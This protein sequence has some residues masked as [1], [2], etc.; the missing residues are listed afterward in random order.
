MELYFYLKWGNALILTDRDFEILK[1][2]YKFKFCLGRHLKVLGNFTGQRSTDRRLRLLVDIGYLTRKKYLFGIPYLYTLTHKGRI[3]LGANKREDKIRIDR[4]TH[5]I[6]VLDSVIYFRD[7]Y[8]LVF[9]D[10]ESEKELHIKDGF[11]ARQHRADF[12]FF[13]DDKKHAVEIELNAYKTKERLEKNV[14]DN[15]MGYDKQIWIIDNKKTF[16]MLKNFT[17][18]YSNIEL[19]SLEVILQ[20][21]KERYK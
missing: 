3:L 1:L 17:N 8:N 16:T 12:V 7:K 18:E 14:R 19:I 13:Y 9:S 6:Y 10:I 15:Y 5:D 4:I 20:Y 2:V 21:I 11:G